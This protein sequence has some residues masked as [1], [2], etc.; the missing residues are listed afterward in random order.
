MLKR[1]WDWIKSL[2]AAKDDWE[3][4]NPKERLIYRYHNGK[5][6]VAADPMVLMKKV[7]AVSTELSADMKVA[8]GPQ[9]KWAEEAR[10]KMLAKM[11]TVFDLK[12]LAEGGLGEVE[13]VKLFHHFMTYCNRME[14][15]IAPFAMLSK[16]WEVCKTTSEEN[17][18]TK[19]SS[20]SGSIASASSSEEP[21]SSNSGP[22]SPPEPSSPPSPTISPK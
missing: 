6:L 11:R 15:E 2:F 1:F 19:P 18:V 14:K 22:E 4:Y 21:G 3:T 10:E 8:T 20:D 13:T 12:P 5:E 9:P 17:P 16:P 7:S